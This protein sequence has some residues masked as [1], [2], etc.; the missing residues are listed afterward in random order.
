MHPADLQKV[1]LSL[2]QAAG[3]SNDDAAIVTEALLYAN[4]HGID[5]HGI[6]RLPTFLRRISKGTVN[7]KSTLETV[8]DLPALSVVDAGNALGPIAAYRAMQ[9]CVEKAR[10]TGVGMVGVRNSTN[11][12]AAGFH[13]LQGAKHG[14]IGI[15]ISNAA[16]A[17]AAWGGREPV[18][19]TNPL[20]IAIPRPGH[21]P[22]ILDMATSVVARGKIRLAAKQGRE[23]PLGWALDREGKPTRDAVAA[24]QGTLMPLGGVKG[25]GLALM[26][27]VLAGVITGSAFARMVHGIEEDQFC[28]GVGHLLTAINVRVLMPEDEY[29]ARLEQLFHQVTSGPAAEGVDGIKLPGEPEIEIRKR[30][31]KEGIPLPRRLREEIVAA[32]EA[33]GVTLGGEWR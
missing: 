7:I 10:K 3:L 9:I 33:L 27:E 25:Y 5:S 29:S 6:T 32:A 22:V 31:E 18:L 21:E 13:A 17:M 26:I 16:P 14:M 23:I 28:S 20:S 8:I 12:G 19:G 30:R 11:F 1:S 2:L 4:L 15:V 24:L